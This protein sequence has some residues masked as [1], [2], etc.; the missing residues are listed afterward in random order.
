MAEARHNFKEKA[1]NLMY[2]ILQVYYPNDPFKN[3]D[4]WSTNPYNHQGCCRLLRTS[5]YVLRLIDFLMFSLKKTICP[6]VR[7]MIFCWYRIQDNIMTMT[8]KL[9]ACLPIYFLDVTTTI[10]ST[11][12]DK[13]NG[14]F[15]NFRRNYTDFIV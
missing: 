14:I 3:Q 6:G 9:C 5:P 4:Y 11:R 7:D 1:Q 15:F 12:Y 10:D 13:E 8:F 2:W